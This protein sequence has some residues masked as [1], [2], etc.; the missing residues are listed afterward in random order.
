MEV[1]LVDQGVLQHLAVVAR[2][3]VVDVGFVVDLGVYEW[4]VQKVQVVVKVLVAA[5]N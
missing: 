4:D 5:Q 2:A 1:V 3:Q